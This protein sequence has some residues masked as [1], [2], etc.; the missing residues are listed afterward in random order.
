MLIG[1]DGS[2]KMPKILFFQYSIVQYLSYIQIQ[3]T[4]LEGA[5]KI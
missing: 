4:S 3:K 5:N 2:L 1:F